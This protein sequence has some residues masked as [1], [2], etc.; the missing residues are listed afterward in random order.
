MHAK[1][2]TL[3]YIFELNMMYS[4]DCCHSNT[5]TRQNG[6]ENNERITTF[7][8]KILDFFNVCG[9][10]VIMRSVNFGTV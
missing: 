7:N 4:Q 8:D 9:L 3:I 10:Y 2:L 6:C 5:P 1:L